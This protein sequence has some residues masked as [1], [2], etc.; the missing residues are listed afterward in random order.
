M[1]VYMVC[2]VFAVF[3]VGFI[4]GS[5]YEKDRVAGTFDDGWH[6]GHKAGWEDAQRVLPRPCCKPFP[7]LPI[8]YD[9]TKE[10]Q[11]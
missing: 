9:H 5:L 2:V 3:A 8:P 7:P 1:V 4:L 10:K 11:G 6:D